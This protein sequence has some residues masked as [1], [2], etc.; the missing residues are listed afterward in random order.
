M[1]PGSIVKVEHGQ[2][3]PAN[4]ILFATTSSVN[5]VDFQVDPT[6]V[7]ALINKNALV[8]SINPVSDIHG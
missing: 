7:D 2:K 8:R 6:N 3:I 5:I 4:S 1:C